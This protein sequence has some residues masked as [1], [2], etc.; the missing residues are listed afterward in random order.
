[1]APTGPVRRPRDPGI[2]WRR[3]GGLLVFGLPRAAS[4]RSR[5]PSRVKQQR[6][7]LPYP[8]TTSGNTQTPSIGLVLAVDQLAPGQWRRWR[9]LC[10]PERPRPDANDPRDVARKCLCSG[11]LDDRRTVRNIGGHAYGDCPHEHRVRMGIGHDGDSARRIGRSRVPP[12]PAVVNPFRPGASVRHSDS[13]SSSSSHMQ[14]FTP[15][16]PYPDSVALGESGAQL[17]AS[18]PNASAEGQERC[19]GDGLGESRRFA[20]GDDPGLLLA[21]RSGDGSHR[22][23]TVSVCSSYGLQSDAPIARGSRAGP[24]PCGVLG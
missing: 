11:G 18:H 12:T 7:D 24:A 19:V 4:D 6:L 9:E 2:T 3:P 15:T 22:L 17:T 8:D 10:V 1:M 20:W 13:T 23:G 14:L 5:R 16:S 21:W